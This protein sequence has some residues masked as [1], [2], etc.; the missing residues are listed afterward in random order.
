MTFEATST[1]RP[2][3]LVRWLRRLRR[4]RSGMAAVEFALL[5]PILA[6]LL[7]GTLEFSQALTIDRRVTQIA[8]ATADLVA[9]T[10]KIT[11]SDFNDTMKIV[12]QLMK[13][14]PTA[15]LKIS[16]VAVLADSN[17]QVKVQW[18]CAYQGGTQ[19]AQGA[20]YSLPS[21]LVTPMTHVIIAE[22]EYFYTPPTGKFLIGGVTL[23]EK[24]YLSPRMGSVQKQDGN[25]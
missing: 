1:A 2:S 25:C 11:T 10:D 19:Y 14:N 13:P 9:Q 24:F 17:S 15:P 12:E 6:T 23:K 4:D 16:L 8:S 18:S 5:V 7:L 21:N 20:S 3:R 22:V